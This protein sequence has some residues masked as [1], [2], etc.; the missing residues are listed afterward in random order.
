MAVKSLENRT[1][2]IRLLNVRED[3]E[4][5]TI[6]ATVYI[7]AGKEKY[8]IQKV[9]DYASKQTKSGKP[10]NNDLISSIENVKLA[11]LESFW[12]GKPDTIP[13]DDPIWC[14][15]WLRYDYQTT[16]PESW[17]I[18]EENITLI[19]QENNI[20][21]DEKHIVFPERIVKLI[22]ANAHTLK[23]LISMC[24]FITEIRRAP[25]ATTFFEELS[26]SEQTEWVDELLSRTTYENDDVSVCL[27][28]TGITSGHS[29]LAPATNIKH[30]QSV[31]T[32][33]GNG[34]HNG[35]GTEMAGI[36]YSM[37]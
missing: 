12:V 28:D 34:D 36:A 31:N 9:E 37:T 16:N 17:R 5:N 20:Q 3:T 7:P 8:F 14:E 25:E 24:P 11:M 13:T 10:K 26:N 19:C 22:R 32:T 21:I 6:K 2:G 33:W 35:H 23:N 15:L 27:L 30:I 29:L 18:T 1:Q 4:T